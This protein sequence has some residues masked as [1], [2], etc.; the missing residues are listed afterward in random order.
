[1]RYLVFP[2]NLRFEEYL[3]VPKLAKGTP[4]YSKEAAEEIRQ[5][6]PDATSVIKRDGKWYVIQFLQ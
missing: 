4:V 6:V 1:M 5:S 2:P 3:W